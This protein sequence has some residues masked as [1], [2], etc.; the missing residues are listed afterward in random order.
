MGSIE[1]C[2]EWT[3]TPLAF[4]EKTGAL[5]RP[6]GDPPPSNQRLPEQRLT[7]AQHAVSL[8]AEKARSRRL[9]AIGNR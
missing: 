4:G 2:G 5:G 8:V 1:A 3:L 6:A 7:V 9:S